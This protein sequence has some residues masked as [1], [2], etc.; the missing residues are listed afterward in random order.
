MKNW[1]NK[2]EISKRK[3]TKSRIKNKSKLGE[4][5]TIITWDF[6]V[7]KIFKCYCD[8][9]N[10]M[11]IYYISSF[12]PEDKEKFKK[13]IK[14]FVE[15][16]DKNNFPILVINDLNDGGYI[17]LSQLFMGALSPLMSINL[18]KGR[19]RLT[20]IFKE[21]KEVLEYLN[22]YLLLWKWMFPQFNRPTSKCI[23][24]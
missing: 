16:F 20:Q 4:L 3:S 18:F 15:R 13:T 19:L 8:E 23:I 1:N 9:L 17:S 21:T 14:N 11:N 10:Q 7:D 22:T 2:E 24:F 5:E 12:L 6:K